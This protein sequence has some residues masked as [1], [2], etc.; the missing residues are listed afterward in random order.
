MSNLR[1][2]IRLAVLSAAVLSGVGRGAV[3]HVPGDFSG[4]QAAINASTNGDLILVAPGVY[5]EN[6]GFL[7]KAITLSS[8]NPAD[9]NVVSNTIV[10][11]SGPGSVV[12]FAAGEGSNAVLAGLTLTGGGG[13]ANTLYNAL[14]NGGSGYG[15]VWGGGVYCYKASPTIVGNLIVGN[16]AFNWANTNVGFGAGICC[17]ESA[18]LITRNLIA[19]N[20]GTYGGG[21]YLES[22]N[23]RFADNVI[24][25]NYA[26]FVGGASLQSAAQFNNNTLVGNS[27]EYQIG[28]LYAG[29][30]SS[31]PGVIVNNII[32]GSTNTGGFFL[33]LQRHQPPSSVQR[34]VGQH[35]VGGGRLQLPGRARPDRDER[36]HL[37]RPAIR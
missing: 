36:Q 14:Y 28:N 1:L 2:S 18:A 16:S 10:Q 24:C 8:T 23:V 20:S 32:C 30:D 27:D 35:G 17:L 5:H 26:L 4:I 37:S 29:S 3:I 34:C 15:S 33:D 21:L 31:K 7:G 6:I 25:S 22:G 13:T 11:A 12:A 9:W 19:G